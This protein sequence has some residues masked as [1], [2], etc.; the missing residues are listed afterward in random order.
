MK[1]FKELEQFNWVNPT[2]EELNN[3][4]NNINCI[5]EKLTEQQK[6]ELYDYLKEL[7]NKL[8]EIENLTFD[9]Y[10]IYDNYKDRL[11]YGVE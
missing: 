2:K 7:E 11:Y 5:N 1:I 8:E 10:D 9:E 6:I 4:I 3:M